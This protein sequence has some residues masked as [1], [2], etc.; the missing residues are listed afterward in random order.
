MQHRVMRL[1]RRLLAGVAR[2]EHARM[3]DL[4]TARA[5]LYP[6]GER[7]ERALNLIP[8]LSRH[9]IALLT[10]MR[11]AAGQHASR[12]VEGTSARPRVAPVA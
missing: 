10:E 4:A 12:L 6:F 2:R 1:E 5:S 7:Q 8:T 3:R 11:D 9:G